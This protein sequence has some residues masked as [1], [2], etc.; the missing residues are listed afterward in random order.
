MS[1]EK[2]SY[3]ELVAALV[4]RAREWREAEI[5]EFETDSCKERDERHCA[6]NSALCQIRRA[7]FDL[8]PHLSNDALYFARRK[9]HGR[10]NEKIGA[11][12]STKG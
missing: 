2:R 8:F 6:T 5:Y 9:A 1:S 7:V 10:I 11:G 12:V 4:D 3:S